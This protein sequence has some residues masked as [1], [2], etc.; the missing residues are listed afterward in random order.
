MNSKLMSQNKIKNIYPEQRHTRTARAIDSSNLVFYKIACPHC[1]YENFISKDYI[2]P[3]MLCLHS[4]CRRI[5]K[6]ENY[7]ELNQNNLDKKEAA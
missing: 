2:Y 1:D 6:V 3:Q 4:G 7:Q 5:I